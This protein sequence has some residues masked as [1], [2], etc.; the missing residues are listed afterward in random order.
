MTLDLSSITGSKLEIYCTPTPSAGSEI[1]F[2]GG[3]IVNTSFTA[4]DLSSYTKI[5]LE[6]TSAPIGVITLTPNS[7]NRPFI[8]AIKVDGRLLVD[9]GVWDVS[10]NWSDDCQGDLER[11]HMAFNG[12]LESQSYG[13]GNDEIAWIPPGGIAFQTLRVYGRAEAGNVQGIK[14]TLQGQAEVSFTAT[15]IAAWY[16]IPGPGTLTKLRWTR[17]GPAASSF[18]G[19][20][21]LDGALLVDSGAQWNTSQVW[22]QNSSSDTTF[23]GGSDPEKAFDGD[24][25]TSANTSGDKTGFIQYN[26]TGLTVNTSLKV[27]TDQPVSAAPNAVSGVLGSYPSGTVQTNVGWTDLSFTGPLTSLRIMGS[28][29]GSN[30]APRLTAVEVDG[31]IL[32]DG[33]AV[34]NTSQVGVTT[35]AVKLALLAGNTPSGNAFYWQRKLVL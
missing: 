20:I 8:G 3:N 2:E 19:G 1:L 10:Q 13:L 7:G 26:F 12:N 21:E 24:L 34:W 27:Y 32:V 15:D 17:G 11:A 16:D 35:V 6:N 22:S 30:R 31:A 28:N 4:G 14:Y 18:V 5:V 29:D 23:N 9:S 33:T 25:T